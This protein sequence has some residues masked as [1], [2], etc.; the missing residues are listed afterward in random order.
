MLRA[1]VRNELEKLIRRRWL[2]IVVVTAAVVGLGLVIELATPQPA[3]WKSQTRQQIAQ[4][5]AT[6]AQVQSSPAG[7]P[8]GLKASFGSAVDQQIA[9]EQY[10]IDHNIPPSDWYPAGRAISAI[11]K[12]GFGFLLLLFGWLAA[13]SV[14]QERAERTLGLLLSRPVSRRAVLIGKA[15]ALQIVATAVLVAAMVPV[16]LITGIKHGGWAV[17]T[18]QVMV[19]D[20]PVKGVLAGNIELLPTWSYVLVALVLSLA[21][22][23]LAQALGLLVSILSRG[24]GLAIGATLGALFVLPPLAD[25]MKLALKDPAFLHYTFWPYLSPASELTSNPTIGLGYASAGLSLTVLL[26]WA[27]LFL[28]AAVTFFVRRSETS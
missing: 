19:L 12:T 23:W 16:Y 3:D 5:Q 25:V 8:T 2:L 14:A 24:P 1:V 13:E 6:K 22:V 9:S 20:D 10:L 26:V 15:A 7:L 21:A 11:L 27:V 18:T 4:L 17:L 28:V